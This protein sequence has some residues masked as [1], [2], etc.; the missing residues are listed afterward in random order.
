[1]IYQEDQKLTVFKINWLAMTSKAE[2]KIARELNDRPTIKMRG[3][4]KEF[5]LDDNDALIFNGWDLPII[6]DAEIDRG[7]GTMIMQ[8][9]AMLNI[10]ARDE[11]MTAEEM[12][13]WIEKNEL[14]GNKE[15]L[16]RIL[17]YDKKD[18]GRGGKKLFN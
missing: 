7:D 2:V 3:K 11:K 18:V 16:K 1:M 5:Y 14:T 17:F 6:R 9:N 8:G 13:K 4:R 10:G 15:L 12:K